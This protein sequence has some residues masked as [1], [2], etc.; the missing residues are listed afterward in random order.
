MTKLFLITRPNYDTATFYLHHFAKDAIKIA[1]KSKGVHVTDLEGKKAIR[2]NLEK[3]MSAENP[4][5]VFLN[6]HGDK[7]A[8][9]GHKDEVI[10]DKKNISLSKNKIIYALA[11][12]S[13]AQLGDLATEQGAKAYIGYSDSFMIIRDL[14]F[15]NM[16]G[17]PEECFT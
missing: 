1:K 8:V 2:L 7:T 14:E 11:C 3:S 10:L 13:L 9:W 4:G 16:K 12:D 5:L 6:G 15:L 17:N